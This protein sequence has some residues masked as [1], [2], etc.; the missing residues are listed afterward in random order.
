MQSIRT[1]LVEDK[2]EGASSI[3]RKLASPP[4]AGLAVEH[5]RTLRSAVSR[6]RGGN[7]DVVLLDLDLPDSSGVESVVRLKRAAPDLPIVVVTDAEGE[8]L[9]VRS[10]Q[11]HAE[12]YL[13]KSAADRVVLQRTICHA[14]ERHR[15][16]IELE[17][18]VRTLEKNEARFRNVVATSSDGV[19]VVSREGIVLFA[20]PSAARLIGRPSEE[21]H[22]EMLGYPFAPSMRHELAVGSERVIEVH[23]VESEW[24]GAPVWL[25][26]LFDITY[27][28]RS[29][30]DL[31]DVTARMHSL[32][33]R[34]ERL[35][36]I[37][38][39]TEILNRRG[40]DAELRIELRRKCRTGAPLAAVLLDCDDFKHVNETLGHAGGDAVLK[41]L[42]E[43]LRNSLR[44]SDHV[45]RI[46]GDEFLAL[47]PD[48]RFPEAFQIAERLRLSL[49]PLH[50]TASLGI[51]LVPD[52]TASLDE[53]LVRT[54]S[55]L[56]HSKRDGK[57]RVSTQ[58]G[59]AGDGA[60]QAEDLAR[61]L[62]AGTAFRVLRQPILRLS[63]ESV[64]GWELVP[65]GPAGIFELP[66]DFFRVA[67]ERN[68]LTQVD[69]RCLDTCVQ[70]ARESTASTCWHVN[71]FP[72]TV[73]DTPC[74]RLV[75]LIAQPSAVARFCI[76]ISEQ[77]FIG[78]PS[79][80]REHVRTLKAAGIRV[81]ID[82]VGFGRSSLETLIL[83][84]PDLIKIDARF[85][86]DTARDAGK[87]RSL[88]RMVD[89]LAS[90][91]SELAAEG[92]ESRADLEFLLE[93][94][95]PYGQGPLWGQP[96]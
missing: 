7:L 31:E 52:E 95:V 45:G 17:R 56:Q 14:L 15:L 55:S 18:N 54:Q 30:A 24:D 29:Q 76:E 96:V 67:L 79:L 20:N 84:E 62:Q 37:D 92:I 19:V 60:T 61:Q 58:D 72:S 86:H 77:H 59:G 33:V 5:R 28:K 4:D 57:N 90:L 46:G 12:D 6:V 13:V 64:V 38:P 16:Q 78:E 65:R 49:G 88:R 87:A 3:R 10:L 39:L 80:L 2:V 35:A 41:E 34:L 22:G 47:L 69:L 36:S 75:D 66:R 81:A 25:A 42:A 91:G 89:V 63:D 71:V 23:I 27:H 1:L 32:N 93:L 74:E 83:L 40:L 11:A 9:A 85:V 68:I 82:H 8:S 94:G 48:T 70:R 26:S 44:P 73:L 51:E 21:L 50:L 53:V 43:R